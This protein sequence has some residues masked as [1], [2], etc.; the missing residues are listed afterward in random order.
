MCSTVDELS[1]KLDDII[2]DIL[3]ENKEYSLDDIYE[4]LENQGIQTKRYEPGTSIKEYLDILTS[5]GVLDMENGNFI[6]PAEDRK[7][8]LLMM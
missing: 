3:C 4:Q 6:S 2:K 7:E 8:E 1:N 5:Y